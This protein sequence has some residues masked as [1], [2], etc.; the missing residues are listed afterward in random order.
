MGATRFRKKPVEIEAVRV[1]DALNAAACDWD[2]LPDWLAAAYEAGKVVF[3]AE[4]GTVWLSTPEGVMS[5]KPPGWIVKGVKGEL[6]PCLKDVFELTY[7][8][9]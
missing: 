6:Y 4:V 3:G 7:E 1:D 8:E 2:A 9:A 5:A